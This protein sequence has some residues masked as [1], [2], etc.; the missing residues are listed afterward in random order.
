VVD[1]SQGAINL[2][3]MG[4]ERRRRAKYHEVRS[5]LVGKEMQ[6]QRGNRF[7][8]AVMEA[9]ESEVTRFRLGDKEV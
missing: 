2:G 5:R 3:K 1:N 6:R 7:S 4:T 9:D 8:V